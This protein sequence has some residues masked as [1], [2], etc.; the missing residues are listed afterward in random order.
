MNEY[1]KLTDCGQVS[2]Q[3]KEPKNLSK[4][5][6]IH[7]KYSVNTQGLSNWL[8]E[9]YNF[10]KNDKLLE[11]GSG[12]GNLWKTSELVTDNLSELVLSDFSEGMVAELAKTYKG[13]K[14]IKTMAIDIQNIP[15][16]AE[17]FDKV[18]ANFMLYH[19]Q[20]ID[21]ALQEVYRV[22]KPGG[23]FYCATAG[24]DHLI[25]INLWLKE[26]FQ[27]MD[28]FNSS[29]LKFNLQNGYEQLRKH[30]NTIEI[31]EYKDHLEISNP[32]DLIEYIFTL[33]EM[34]NIDETVKNS[35]KSFI[36]TKS[37]NRGIIKISKQSGTFIAKKAQ[38]IN[39]RIFEEKDKEDISKLIAYF[40]EELSNLKGIRKEP[41]IGKAKE[42]I[43]DY[44]NCKYPIFVAKNKDNLLI[45]YI[46]CKVESEVVW[47]ESLYVL[48]E[49][50]RSGIASLLFNEAEKLAQ[51]YGNDT[52]Y[53]WVHP[54]NH[55]MIM[56]LDKKGYDVLNLIEIRKSWKGEINTRKI[57]V[58]DHEFKY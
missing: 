32:D 35:L 40:R 42:E 33:N 29:L 41:D 58:D 15:F 28:V 54:N 11:L 8:F 22:L 52:V 39:I 17:C 46:I 20:D 6:S 36:K 1:N 9:N 30:F 38:V 18:I 50:R 4:R 31:L 51:K 43:Q 10:S 14:N 12:T 37:D 44:I 34:M 26:F 45:G 3:Y 13:Y 56:F 16:E 53:N 47:A 48:P 49:Y 55:S 25:E 2:L 7:E 5:I 57:K 23:T 27:D 24:S 21:L 19:V